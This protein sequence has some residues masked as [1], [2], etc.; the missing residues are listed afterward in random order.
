MSGQRMAKMNIR[1]AVLILLCLMMAVGLAACGQPDDID[2]SGYSSQTIT[3]TGLKKTAVTLKISD[4]KKMD[5]ETI[6][7]ESTSDKIGSCAPPVRGWIL[8]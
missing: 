1:K 2:I 3:I 7:A 5:C 6:K 8:C 4:L